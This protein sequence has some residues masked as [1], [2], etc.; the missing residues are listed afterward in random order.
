[1]AAAA[2]ALPGLLDQA[3][4]ERWSST[5][6]LERVFALEVA[7]ADTRRHATLARFACLPAPWKISDF[8]FSAQ[9]SVDKKLITELETLRF[10]DDA[11]SLLLIG[12]PGV[13]KTMLS[14]GLGWA[15]V[16]AGH[17]VHYTTASDLAARCHKAALEGRW[18]NMMRFYSS[19]RLLIIDELGYLPLAEE[20]AAAL[21]QVVTQRYLKASTCIT[22]NL[23]IASWAKVT[24]DPVVA[25]AM[26]DRLL[27]R[28]VVI[29]IDGPSY[30]MRAHRARAEASRK[31][32]ASGN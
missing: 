5:A 10:L 12:P 32:V 21:F 13:G 9:P 26:L 4:A 25:A 27:H 30:R 15:A 28:S 18:A 17:K 16:D 22:T 8:D 20:A 11:T 24:G 19:P 6:L 2:E 29:N 3:K 7:A 1:M 31:A 14:I 23:G